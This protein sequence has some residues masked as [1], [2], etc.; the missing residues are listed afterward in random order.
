MIQV[1]QNHHSLVLNQMALL[2]GV[3]L[4]RAKEVLKRAYI[5]KL[6][7]IKP[8]LLITAYSYQLLSIGQKLSNTVAII[9]TK[10]GL[11]HRRIEERLNLARE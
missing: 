6:R 10:P 4:C 2:F 11:S 9:L 5:T 1:L 8:T 3:A 7:R